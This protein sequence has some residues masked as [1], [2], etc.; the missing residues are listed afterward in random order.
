MRKTQILLL[1]LFLVS[2]EKK[3]DCPDIVSGLPEYEDITNQ[4][5]GSISSLF[6]LNGLNQENLHFSNLFIDEFGHRH[7]SC[8]QYVN[9]LKILSGE[10]VYH[11][12]GLGKFYW[13]SGHY[14][15]I[16][17]LGT[18]PDLAVADLKNIYRNSMDNDT[19]F[20]SSSKQIAEGCVV[21]ELGYFNLNSGTEIETPLWCLAW[22]VHPDNADY[23]AAIINDS[24]GFLINYK[25][26]INH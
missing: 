9:N 3:H 18:V 1:V 19:Y 11:F 12:N 20:S 5:L 23:P 6:I 22:N 17:D 14:A 21:C 10:L 8:Y 7:A 16:I 2:C 25:N 26:G 4:E 15:D 13:L 24:N